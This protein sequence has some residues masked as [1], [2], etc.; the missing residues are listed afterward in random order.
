[1]VRTS[2]NFSVISWWEQVTFRWDVSFVVYFLFNH[3]GGVMVS[4][5]FLSVVDH[6]F[7]QRSG[8]TKWTGFELTTSVMIGTNRT[9]SW[10]SNYHTI[11]TAPKCRNVSMSANKLDHVKTHTATLNIPV[12]YWI[13]ILA[14]TYLWFTLCNVKK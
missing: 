14:Q 9:G 6:L 4:V 10:K 2:N 12:L 8:E 11:T 7:E 1:M 13:D 5:L 3:I